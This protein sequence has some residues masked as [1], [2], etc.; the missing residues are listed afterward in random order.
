MLKII[1]NEPENEKLLPMVDN[2]SLAIYSK[3]RT[4][5]SKEKQISEGT[6]DY[7]AGDLTYKGFLNI[8]HYLS[9]N[10]HEVLIATRLF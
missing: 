6:V 7:N 2:Y 1:N 5:S 9:M 4:S 10:N 8:L 3:K